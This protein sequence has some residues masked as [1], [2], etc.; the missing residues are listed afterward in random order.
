MEI[1]V[2]PL[3]KK[4]EKN[5]KRKVFRKFFK[6]APCGFCFLGYILTCRR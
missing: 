6:K 5:S 2:N 4:D 3:N 1:A